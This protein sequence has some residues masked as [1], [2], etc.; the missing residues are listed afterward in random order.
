[1]TDAS[2]LPPAQSTPSEESRAQRSPIRELASAFSLG[3]LLR[4]G[5]AAA[6]SLRR[7]PAF[8]LSV[9]VILSIVIGVVSQRGRELCIRR[10]L[11]A[12]RPHIVRLIMRQ[13]ATRIGIA[14]AL[15]LMAAY[16]A[17]GLYH[18]FL[19]DVT[20]TDPMTYVGV[21][22][23][24]VAVALL[25]SYLPSRRAARVDPIEALRAE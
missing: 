4:D 10:S 2:T 18:L 3:N 23:V 24:L 19:F 25:A 7:S 5:R 22:A 21:S 1:M 20:A 9:I 11:G 15:G 8:S 12:T 16:L 14:L 6:R 13:A 17:R